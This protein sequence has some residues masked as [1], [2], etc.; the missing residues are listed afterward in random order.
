M[1]C[2]IVLVAGAVFSIVGVAAG[3][4]NSLD[5]M[6]DRYTWIRA[7]HADMEYLDI[8][9]AGAFDS[10]N[11]KGGIDVVIEGSA[12]AGS[13]GIRYDRNVGAPEYSVKDGVLTVDASKLND[14]VIVNLGADDDTPELVISAPDGALKKL[15]IT[16][17]Y[18]DVEL[19][20]LTLE[21]V[22]VEAESGD[23]DMNRITCSSMTLVAQYGDIEGEGMK[24][25][26][27]SA[28]SETGDVSLQGEFSGTTDLY[29]QNGDLELD[30]SLAKELYTID[31]KTERGEIEIASVSGHFDSDDHD[32]DHGHY[33]DDDDW[34][35]DDLKHHESYG[36]SYRSGSGQNILKM[37]VES[38]DIE[39][40]FGR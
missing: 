36:G 4:L 11:V 21:N 34:D 37:I 26:G 24:C 28:K 33:D 9:D 29:I 7:G 22:N 17:Q 38:G 2:A 8:S 32:G 16:S 35:D 14:G 20:D 15:D 30:T 40:G 27:L 1:I 10:I 19:R 18:G 23:I 39:M 31:A 6:S 3:G 12:T 25:S 13:S 5:K